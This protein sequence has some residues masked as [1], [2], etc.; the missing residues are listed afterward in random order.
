MPSIR[1]VV[2]NLPNIF[3]AEKAKGWNRVILLDLGGEEPSK[4]TLTIQDGVLTV[5]EGQTK[6]PKLIIT[7]NSEH[8]VQMF[9][10][11]VPPMKLVNAKLIKMQGPMM[12]A[13]AFSGLWNIPKKEEKNT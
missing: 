10:G 1:D 2:M 8:I 4:W 13:I 6:P 5:E 11:E 9:T 12:D 7:G 3:K